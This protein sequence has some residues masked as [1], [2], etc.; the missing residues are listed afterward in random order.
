MLTLDFHNLYSKK[1]LRL[2]LGLICL[3]LFAMQSV[4]GQEACPPPPNYLENPLSTPGI[5]AAEVAANPTPDN[6]RM[7]AAAGRD[8]LLS[9]TTQLELAHLSCL[10]RQELSLIHI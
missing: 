9:I 2:F 3:M 1:S 10:M 7:F 4:S 6:L 8:Y 5:T